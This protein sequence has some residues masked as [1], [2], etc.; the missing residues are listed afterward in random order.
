MILVYIL[1]F[2]IL[3]T[4]GIYMTD[5][6]FHADQKLNKKQQTFIEKTQAFH[7]EQN[8][9]KG[10]ISLMAVTLTLI[11]SCLFMYLTLKMKV[12]LKEARYRKD[13]YLCFHY[14]NVETQNYIETMAKFNLGLRGLFAASLLTPKAKAAFDALKIARDVRHFSY[15]KNLIKNNYCKGATD[16]L[17]Y[18]KKFPFETNLAFIL[19]TNPDAT[20]RLRS[21]KWQVI[22]YKNP[23]GIRL[24]KSFCLFGE[25]EAEGVIRPNLKL[26]T[27]EF[28]M[29]GLSKLKCS[30]GFL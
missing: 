1:S 12:E 27:S 17:A 7:K 24:N 9:N 10:N 14:L 3:I 26:K 25:F 16:S 19:T 6:L 22:T 21:H 30:S 29:K 11:I 5:V 4:S 23:K 13:S 28:P 20:T 15:V 2:S 8:D 18:L